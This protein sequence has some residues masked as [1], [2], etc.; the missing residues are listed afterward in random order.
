MT[1]AMQNAQQEAANSN[2]DVKSL[3]YEILARLDA[4]KAASAPRG[5]QYGDANINGGYV[6]QGDVNYYFADVSPNGAESEHRSKFTTLKEQRRRASRAP[7][8]QGPLSFK[9]PFVSLYANHAGFNQNGDNRWQSE[10]AMLLSSVT[11]PQIS[12]GPGRIASPDFTDVQMSDQIPV[13][14]R[15]PHISSNLPLRIMELNNK[16]RRTGIPASRDTNREFSKD[17]LPSFMHAEAPTTQE[18]E[19][20]LAHIFQPLMSQSARQDVLQREARA[21]AM[22]RWVHGFDNLL[23]TQRLSALSSASREMQAMRPELQTA[24]VGLLCS[25][26]ERLE[27]ANDRLRTVLYTSS[28]VA[29]IDGAL[30]KLLTLTK[31]VRVEKEVEEFRD[32]RE[33]SGWKP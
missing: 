6:H 11:V 12:N 1:I 32:E 15:E 17:A 13:E 33:R 26:N 7:G 23:Q 2:S 3:V 10:D 30:D 9:S 24:S 21:N 25:L 19:Q 29:G 31:S 4:L 28:S 27:G 20:G 16:R 22:A 8:G 14:T 5:N 18:L